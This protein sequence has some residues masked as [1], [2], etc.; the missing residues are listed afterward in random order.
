MPPLCCLAWK[1]DPLKFHLALI[2][3][4]IVYIEKWNRVRDFERVFL[5]RT[6]NEGLELDWV[7]VV[8]VRVTGSANQRVGDQEESDLCESGF[9]T[10]DNFIASTQEGGIGRF[11]CLLKVGFKTSNAKSAVL[12][13]CDN[14]KVHSS[15]TIICLEY[16]LQNKRRVDG[17][18]CP[19]NKIVREREKMCFL[20]LLLLL[21]TR[22]WLK[23][24]L[25]LPLHGMNATCSGGKINCFLSVFSHWWHID[26]KITWD[27]SI[28]TVANCYFGKKNSDIHKNQ[29]TRVN[30]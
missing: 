15:V 28:L 2:Q 19:S 24:Y 20:L 30:L 1:Y 27:H 23:V 3:K 14:F 7:N 17:D 9:N 16:A 6:K 13:L 21:L 25:L 11:Q 22:E 26:P 10:K 29:K 4:S 5:W 18:D 8:V 12:F